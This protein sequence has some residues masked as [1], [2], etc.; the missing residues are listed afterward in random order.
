MASPQQTLRAAGSQ[1]PAFPRRLGDVI[2]DEWFNYTITFIFAANENQQNVI[3]IQSDAHFVAVSG[4]YNTS[5]A[6]GAGTFQG[7]GVDNGGAL[8]QITDGG[9]S[10]QLSSAQ[11][12]LNTIFGSAQRPGIFELT[13]IF[14]AN[15][16]IGI[17]ITGTTGA[18]Q[19]VRLVFGGFKIP[20]GSAR[21]LGLP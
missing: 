4:K 9:N 2:R 21:E 5:A 20:V 6:T 8:I 14:L 15:T 10:R 12:P 1:L 3:P 13:H 16:N 17:S 18:A 19:T 7:S 11:V